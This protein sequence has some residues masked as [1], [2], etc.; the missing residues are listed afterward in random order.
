MRVR[1]ESLTRVGRRRFAELFE[2]QYSLGHRVVKEVN[3]N[4]HV[5][6]QGHL[7]R[8]QQLRHMRAVEMNLKPGAAANCSLGGRDLRGDWVRLELGLHCCGQEEQRSKVLHYDLL[9]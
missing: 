2:I 4:P 5:V 1:A 9:F 3:L 7:G 8:L 6:G